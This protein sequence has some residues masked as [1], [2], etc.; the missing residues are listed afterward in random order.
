MT[1]H[2]EIL[3]IKCI[4]LMSIHITHRI[5]VQVTAQ[6]AKEAIMSMRS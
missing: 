2:T 3:V 6:V 4:T 5:I 1:L